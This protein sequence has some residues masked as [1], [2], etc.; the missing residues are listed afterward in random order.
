MKIQ[1][2][3][4]ISWIILISFKI[5]FAIEPVK[6]NTNL[7]FDYATEEKMNKIISLPSVDAFEKL[8]SLDFILNEDIFNNT[9]YR[10]FKYRKNEGINLAIKAITKKISKKGVSKIVDHIYELEIA[11]KIFEVFPEEYQILVSLY[12]NGDISTKVNII[13]ISAV[14]SNIEAKKILLIALNDKTIYEDP[15]EETDIPMRI[16]DFAYNQIVL[17]YNIKGIARVLGTIDTIKVRD[18]Y[19]SKLKAKLREK[20][21]F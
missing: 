19:I 13:N 1:Y 4:L 10:A 12:N 15:Y 11:K 18:N 21:I 9:V 17:R 3:F 6:P 7:V 2:F 20:S 5:A 14:N 8:K 16:C